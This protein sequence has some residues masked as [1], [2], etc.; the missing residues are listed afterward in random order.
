MIY[1]YF[2]FIFQRYKQPFFENSQ[3]TGGEGKFLIETGLSDRTA[4]TETYQQQ[5]FVKKIECH[6]EFIVYGS[7]WAGEYFATE[8]FYPRYYN[9]ICLLELEVKKINLLFYFIITLNFKC[10]FF[11][12]NKN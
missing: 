2:E 4:P 5:I 7:D 6:E 11:Y 3:Q 1:F 9:D 12:S 10:V 8:P